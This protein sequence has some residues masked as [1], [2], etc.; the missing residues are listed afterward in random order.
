MPRSRPSPA[1]GHRAAAAGD[2][3]EPALGAGW[4]SQRLVRF[5]AALGLLIGPSAWGVTA[6][7]V[8]LPS[9]ATTLGTDPAAMAWPITAYIAAMAM[10]SAVGGR[11]IG[12]K[13]VVPVLQ[14]GSLLLVVGTVGAALSSGLTLFTVS[15]LVLGAGAGL[16]AAVS[17]GVAGEFAPASRPRVL[18]V[19]AAVMAG[20][21]GTGPLLGGLLEGLSWRASMALPIVA[22]LAVPMIWRVGADVTGRAGA[23]IDGA[24]ALLLVAAAGGA[25]LLIQAS[26]TDM[27]A[28]GMWLIAAVTVLAAILLAA[29]VR[30]VPDGFLPRSVVGQRSLLPWWIAGFGGQAGQV[31]GLVLVPVL[32]AQGTTWSPATVG[33][34]LAVLSVA[35]VVSSPLAARGAADRRGPYFAAVAAAALAAGLIATAWWHPA[36][37]LVLVVAALSFGAFSAMQVVALQRV[38]DQV[39][40]AM[41]PAATGILSLV[42]LVGGAVGSAVA[43]T[44]AS[45]L[46]FGAAGWIPALLPLLAAVAAVGAAQ[47][48]RRP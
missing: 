48:T 26:A 39:P 36:T 30:S 28:G 10:A 6:A 42:F 12:A 19:V 27:G 4:T 35:G 43:S 3:S 17:F 44:S 20:S 7:T 32:L 38:C 22:V 8:V 15:R 11:T 47:P 18:A 40:A 13:G 2:P 23:T 25:I 37:W 41:V 14:I 31:A 5:G 45:L 24:G 29:R 33:L 21:V 1:T 46:G 9:A 16:L 34:V